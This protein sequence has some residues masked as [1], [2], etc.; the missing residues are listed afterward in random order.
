ML[1]WGPVKHFLSLE[2][3]ELSV[4]HSDSNWL[5]VICKAE[6]ALALASIH[7]RQ[8][9]WS[10]HWSFETRWNWDVHQTL[11]LRNVTKE[12]IVNEFLLSLLNRINRGSILESSCGLVIKFWLDRRHSSTA[13]NHTGGGYILWHRVNLFLGQWLLDDFHLCFWWLLLNKLFLNR[14]LFSRQ[15]VEKSYVPVDFTVLLLARYRFFIGVREILIV[16][17]HQWVLWA[18]NHLLKNP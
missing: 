12:I 5:D 14:L 15:M 11:P 8:I 13:I 17:L 2:F 9:R 4:F 10:I 7:R 16:K 6:W 3:W 1:L 18:C